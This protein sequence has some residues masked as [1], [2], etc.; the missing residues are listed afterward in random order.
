MHVAAQCA[1]SPA[2]RKNEAAPPAKDND[3]FSDAFLFGAVVTVFFF[4]AKISYGYT[5]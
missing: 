5:I 3:H 1:V 4:S 2:K